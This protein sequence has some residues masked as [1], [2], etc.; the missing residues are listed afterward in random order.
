MSYYFHLMLCSYP[1]GWSLYITLRVRGNSRGIITA[2]NPPAFQKNT[3]IFN[4]TP[5][6]RTFGPNPFERPFP[7]RISPSFISLFGQTPMP[8][9]TK[10]GADDDAKTKWGPK[11]REAV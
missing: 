9:R 4:L 8:N 11:R 7:I 10:C 5:T 3:T 2:V 6:D 1:T